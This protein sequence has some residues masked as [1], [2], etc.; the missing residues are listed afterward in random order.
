MELKEK[1]LRVQPDVVKDLTTLVSYYS[2]FVPGENGTPF[3]QANKDCLDKALEIA[4]GY[5]FKTKNVDD[6]CGYI[7][8]GEGEDIVGVL[9]HLDVVPCS[10]TWATDPTVLTHIGD[11]YYGRGSTDDKGA[12]VCT[13]HAM[14]IIREL[15]I[16]M[17][18]RVRLIL[19]C[20]EEN[21]SN[22]IKHYVESGEEIVSCGFT[23]DGYFPLIYGEKGIC[24]ADFIGKSE[25]I[26]DIKGGTVSNAVPAKCVFTLAPD[27]VDKEKVMA[28]LAEKGMGAS[29]DG[30]V[31]T[32]TGVAAHAMS[33]Q[34]GKNAISHGMEALYVGGIDDSFVNAYH[35]K[36]GLTYNGEKLGVDFVDEY[37]NLTLNI[38][39]ASM[40]D[41]VIKCTIDIRFPV[42][43]TCEKVADTLTAN[44]EGYVKVK[45]THVPLFFSLDD[46]QIKAMLEAYYK[47]KGDNS[48]KPLVIGGGTYAKAMPNIVAFGCEDM[49]VDSHIHDDNEFV[50]EESL[51]FQTEAYAEAIINLL[52]I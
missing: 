32:V 30:D 42:T 33:P 7:E 8:M 3:G 1:V 4:E 41:G 12:A 10:D 24:S 25:K 47:V 36:V 5:G 19:G 13:L 14:R 52:K 48:E 29:F 31:L 21:G 28:Y 40:T 26:L 38:G 35:E 34:L 44:G 15:G 11:K 6:M 20:N 2:V 17:N 9:A 23:P 50:S 27:C 16:P 43:L 22:G 49:D 51:R 37:S 45:G 46:P 18:K 39:V